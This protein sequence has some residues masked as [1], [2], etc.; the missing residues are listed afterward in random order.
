M[1][2]NRSDTILKYIVEYFIKNAQPIGSRT[3]IEEYNVPYSS[4]TIR[5]EMFAL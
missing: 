4:A 1:S 3:L 2:L 5:N